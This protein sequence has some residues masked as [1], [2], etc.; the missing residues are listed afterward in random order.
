MKTRQDTTV[1]TVNAPLMKPM[2]IDEDSLPL[3]AE[4]LIRQYS[5]SLRSG[6]AETIA[7]GIDSH[8]AKG[9]TAP[10]R[11]STPDDLNPNV[12]IADCG[13]GMSLQ[14]IEDVYTNFLASSKRDSDDF[15]G[16]YGIGAKSLFAVTSSF[17]LV[18]VH[19]GVRQE[20]WLTRD[21]SGAPVYA[22]LSTEATDAPTGVTVTFPVPDPKAAR[23]AIAWI[24]KLMPAGALL[25]DGEPN[26]SL[27]TE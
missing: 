10:V 22:V 13:V 2:G 21:E 19:D 3:L 11:L 25:I 17:T 4:M 18:S 14:T 8:V 12:V 5:N 9:V 20:V 6:I 16:H 26:E 1:S 7:N 24:G 15:T 23:E 27:L